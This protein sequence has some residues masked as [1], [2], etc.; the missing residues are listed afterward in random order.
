MSRTR[1]TAPSKQYRKFSHTL[2]KGHFHFNR[3]PKHWSLRRVIAAKFEADRKCLDEFASAPF[4]H[5]GG[6]T[7]QRYARMAAGNHFA[8]CED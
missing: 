2:A 5:E 8:E 7:V 1:R 4:I 3:P 6:E